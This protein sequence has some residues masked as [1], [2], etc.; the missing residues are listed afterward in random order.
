MMK[1]TNCTDCGKELKYNTRKPKLCAACKLKIKPKKPK[2]T[3]RRFPKNKGTT[4][5]MAMFA[6]LDVILKDFDFINHG[7]Y[8]FLISPK[9]SPLQLDRYYPELKLAFEYDGQQHDKYI[10]YIHKARK[11]FE[12]YKECDGLKEVLCKK[13]G[14]TLIRVSYR[15]KLTIEDL[16]V[17][18]KS[19]GSEELLKRLGI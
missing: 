18:I 11:N 14:I 2:S 1:I 16:L 6:V 15:Q 12:Y 10:R 13:K 17:L 5:E 8:S 7:Y 3:G 4:G 19:Q 9:G